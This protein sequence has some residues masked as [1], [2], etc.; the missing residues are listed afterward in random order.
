MR[1]ITSEGKTEIFYLQES[2]T[3][4]T[5]FY[6]VYAP[7]DEQ[8][9]LA[10]SKG[11]NPDNVIVLPSGFAIL[12]GPGG[13]PVEGE[14]KDRGSNTGSLLTVGF[15]IIDWSITNETPITL[16]SVQSIYGVIADTVT[17][18]K[19]AVQYHNRLN[20]WMNEE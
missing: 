4:S 3:D 1:A 9:L 18:I 16:E 5:G 13:L 19:D 17:A 2:Y 15:N 11:C 7:L 20:N 12:P 14:G 10:L 6:V 8:A